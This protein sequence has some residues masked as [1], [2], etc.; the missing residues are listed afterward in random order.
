MFIVVYH[1]AER[2][3][4]WQRLQF[5]LKYRSYRPIRINASCEIDINTRNYYSFNKSLYSLLFEIYNS[6][7]KTRSALGK[8]TW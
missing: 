6:P 5:L 8:S 7:L 2:K 1:P 4:E 3:R